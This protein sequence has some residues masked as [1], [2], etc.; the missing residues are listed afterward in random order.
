MQAG[1]RQRADRDMGI[2]D[3]AT[4]LA[5][6]VGCE[7]GVPDVPCGGA[8]EN[9]SPKR[10][11]VV[12]LEDAIVDV[13]HHSLSH[14]RPSPCQIASTSHK[15]RRIVSDPCKDSRLIM[16]PITSIFSPSFCKHGQ[17]PNLK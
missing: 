14:H 4:L 2:V 13:S 3:G 15:L 11:G 17:T 10:A 7:G 6:S 9:A 16:V 1:V 12:V 8:P 5:R